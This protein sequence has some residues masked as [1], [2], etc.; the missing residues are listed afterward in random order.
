MQTDVV[1]KI[2]ILDAHS[3]NPGDLSWDEFCSL[4]ETV[5]YARTSPDEIVERCRGAE[6]VLTNKV[7]F[8]A[9]TIEALPELRYIGVLATG[10]NIIDITASKNHGV[11]V[12]NIPS[13]STDSVAQMTIAHLLNITNRVDEYAGEVSGGSWDSCLDFCYWNDPITELAGKNMGIVGYGNI[14]EAVARV[15]IALGMKVVT[16][17]SRDV[18]KLPDGVTQLDSLDEVF[19]QS[20]VL[21]LHCPLTDDTYHLINA[22]TLSLMKSSAILINTARGALID[23]PALAEALNNGRIAAAALDVLD[24]EPPKRDNPL[25]GAKHCYITPHIAW[26]STEARNRLIKI[27]FDNLKAWS[28]G[29]PRNVVK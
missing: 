15:A 12:T 23:Q 20:D 6:V 18:A 2:V 25:L 14:G 4:G 1:M 17:T 8:T 3:L 10:Y 28:E 7:P 24:P 9:A 16:H 29:N 26:A 27:A 13:Y 22:R 19:K 11:V 21:S 5:L